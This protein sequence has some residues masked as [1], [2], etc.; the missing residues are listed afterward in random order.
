[1]H[2]GEENNKCT[3]IVTD[4]IQK[5]TVPRFCFL[6][7]KQMKRNTNLVSFSS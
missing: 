1:M 3:E 2:S 4:L 5:S 7:N 6:N